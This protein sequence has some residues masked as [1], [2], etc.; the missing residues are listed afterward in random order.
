MYFMSVGKLM[1]SQ[2]FDFTSVNC[3]IHH[4]GCCWFA[5]VCGLAMT[6]GCEKQSKPTPP[7]RVTQPSP[8]TS[9]PVVA[10]AVSKVAP[11][12]PT[13]KP[14]KVVHYDPP[15]QRYHKT[16][17]QVPNVGEVEE[18]RI[19]LTWEDA[20]GENQFVFVQT[21][22][23]SGQHKLAAS[24]IMTHKVRLAKQPWRVVRI[25]KERLRACDKD[26]QAYVDLRR[27]QVTDLNSNQIKEVT[28][29]YSVGCRPRAAIVEGGDDLKSPQFTIA[30]A[31][32]Q[33]VTHKVL[34]AEFGQKY[35]IRGKT[36]V[37]TKDADFRGESCDASREHGGSK[38]IDPEL[39]KAPTGFLENAKQV[40]R[41]TVREPFKC[42]IIDPG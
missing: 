22:W 33:P 31:P 41:R 8:M 12:K 35:A 25:Y 11:T 2:V 4:E 38:R 9:T 34:M 28:W 30:T 20:K 24:V 18:V 40:W 6:L 3:E 16:T 27:P 32:T 14:P 1:I 7:P 23:P 5:V 19:D 37:P 39:Y 13:P 10:P 42:E 17:R 15:R 26:A 36:I 21:R 29:A